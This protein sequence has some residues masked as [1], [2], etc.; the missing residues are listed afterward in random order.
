MQAIRLLAGNPFAYET[1][2]VSTGVKSLTNATYGVETTHIRAFITI[3]G[4]IMRYRYDGTN[5]SST[6]GHLVGHGDIITVE[7]RPNVQNFRITRAGNNDGKIQVTY[8]K[9]SG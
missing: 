5:A 9:V 4:G 3:E 8:E 1:L 6:V 7:G 2:T